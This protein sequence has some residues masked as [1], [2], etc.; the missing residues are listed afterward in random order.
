MPYISRLPWCTTYM[1][2]LDRG[3]LGLDRGTLDTGTL[4]TGR[5]DSRFKGRYPRTYH[6]PG[7]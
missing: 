1:G 4:D 2:A 6:T 3:T 5:L 7:Y